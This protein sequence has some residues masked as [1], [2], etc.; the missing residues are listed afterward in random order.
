MFPDHPNRMSSIPKV[1]FYYVAP[2]DS[3][4]Q[5]SGIG[6]FAL[7]RQAKDNCRTGQRIIEVIEY[8]KQQVRTEVFNKP[9]LRR[10][11]PG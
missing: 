8:A 5:V 10:P 7:L 2:H 1:A 4:T 6:I 3:W 9:Q 11:R